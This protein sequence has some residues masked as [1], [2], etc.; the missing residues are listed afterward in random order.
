MPCCGFCR[1]T[2]HNKNSC[3]ELTKLDERL[4]RRA[5]TSDFVG[6][7]PK[8]LTML[9]EKALK[10]HPNLITDI[11]DTDLRQ[12]INIY[13]N[14]MGNISHPIQPP[15]QRERLMRE[16]ELVLLA[17][18]IDELLDRS[19][20]GHSYQHLVKKIPSNIPVY[21][22]DSMEKKECPICY[23]E[24]ITN[25]ETDCQHSYC[26]NCISSSLK[27]KPTCAVCRNN[28]KKIY[29]NISENTI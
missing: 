16:D 12:L 27:Y 23:T 21:K 17:S 24:N 9:L 7:K 10:T 20:E 26:L 8:Q 11:R 4:Y 6:L 1:K 29:I 25:C 13:V 22:L 15:P 2:G 5:T 18:K 3:D 19:K 14:K 28:I